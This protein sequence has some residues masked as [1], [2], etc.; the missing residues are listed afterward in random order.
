MMKKTIYLLL[1]LSIGIHLR[2]YSQDKNTKAK[3]TEEEKIEFDAIMNPIVQLF[4]GM[5]KGDSAQVSDV[6]THN[7]TMYTSFL[8]RQEKPVLIEDNLKK[9]LKAI[10]SP[11]EKEWNELFWDEEVRQD[12]TLAHVWVSYAFYLGEGFSHCGVNSF[13]LHKGARGWKIFNITDTRRVKGCEVPDL[14]DK[15]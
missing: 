6:F 10:G 3:D 8:N 2:A 9:F 13:H 5:R 12:G 15:P 14:P 4:D 1:L 7:A 11:H